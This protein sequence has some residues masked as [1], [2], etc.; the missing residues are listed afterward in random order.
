MTKKDI[1]M[2]MLDKPYGMILTTGPTGSGKTTTLYTFLNFLN[3][4]DVK[5]ITLEDPIEYRLKGIQQIQMDREAGLDFATGLRSV[6]RHDP[7]V[8]LV[9]EI[10]DLETAEIAINAAQTGHIVFSTLHTNDAAGV[11]P[12]MIN[13]GLRQFVIAPAVNAII[14]QRLVRVLCENCKQEH[15]PT[16]QESEFVKKILGQDNIEKY[17]A[18][19]Y[20][21]YKAGQC[22][23]CVL[24][25]IWWGSIAPNV[26]EVKVRILMERMPAY[27][28]VK[29]APNHFGPGRSVRRFS[30]LGYGSVCLPDFLVDPL[31]ADACRGVIPRDELMEGAVRSL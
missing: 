2:K 4:P 29:S 16:K 7:D 13:M 11:L 8:V 26:S 14:A 17:V 6:L 20:K 24:L 19:D 23:K 22:D 12:R 27:R 28:D 21:L 5:I 3:K 30:L 18:R 9:G 31:G 1:I 25:F 10:R 15:E